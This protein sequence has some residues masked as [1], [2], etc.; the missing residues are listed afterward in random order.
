MAKTV[1][2]ITIDEEMMKQA[3]HRAAEELKETLVHSGKYVQVTRCK[4]CKWYGTGGCAISINDESD[5]PGDNDYCS[6][7]DEKDKGDVN[8]TDE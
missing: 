7:A 4:D 5:R 6:F 3:V 1:F 2:T 8:E